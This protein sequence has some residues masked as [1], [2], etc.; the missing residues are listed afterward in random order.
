MLLTRLLLVYQSV[1]RF[2]NYEFT[3]AVVSFEKNLAT[4]PQIFGNKHMP[5]MYV[6]L[7]IGIST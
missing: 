5:N 4:Y 2:G 6:S 7:F 1:Q 3:Y